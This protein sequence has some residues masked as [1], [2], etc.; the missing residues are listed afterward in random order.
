[1]QMSTSSIFKSVFTQKFFIIKVE[2]R[3][4]KIP[5]RRDRGFKR[6]HLNEFS[7]IREIF[8]KSKLKKKETEV[9]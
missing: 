5:K 7:A 4:N 1:M 9:S 8:K 6:N 2:L 3:G